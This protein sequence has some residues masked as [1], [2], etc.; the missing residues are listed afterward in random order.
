VFKEEKH[1]APISIT[2]DMLR[3]PT[4]NI[5]LKKF[6][7]RT[8]D[9]KAKVYPIDMLDYDPLTVCNWPCEKCS[10]D[11]DFCYKWDRPDVA[12]KYL[13]TTPTY[14]TCGTA[15][16]PGY[17]TNGNK[18]RHCTACD[19]P[20][21]TCADDGFAGDM[22]KCLTCADGYPYRLE[23]TCVPEC[24]PGT[25]LKGEQCLPC[26]DN[27]FTCSETPTKCTSCK[28]ESVNRFLL[29]EKCTTECLP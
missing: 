10:S 2:L 19:A 3:N 7:L 1:F 6:K 23:E 24:P 29:N 15:C 26:S 17:T 14:S 20:C 11:K 4:S 27:C 5:N 8:Y 28:Q 9:D 12:E 25:Y 21:A 16:H 22:Y 13:T 18:K